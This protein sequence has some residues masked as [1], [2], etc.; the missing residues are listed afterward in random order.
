MLFTV[1]MQWALFIFHLKKQQNNFFVPEQFNQ[2]LNAF[3]RDSDT[4][5]VKINM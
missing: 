2:C 4:Q 1:S 3:Q 5:E